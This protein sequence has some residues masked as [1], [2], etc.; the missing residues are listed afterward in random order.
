MV[1]KQA[2]D[3]VV[4]RVG[5]GE[6]H[7]ADRAPRDLVLI[8]GANAAFGGADLGSGDVSGL[9][10]RV[11]L[12]MQ[13]QNQRDV[14]CDLEVGRGHFDSLAAQRL[15]L[16]DEMIGIEDDAVADNR[17]F[18]RPNNAGRKQCKFVSLAVDHES[19]AGVVAALEPHNDVGA[20]RQPIDDLALSFVAP[21]GAD[22]DNIGQR[23]L[24]FR[25]SKTCKAPAQRRKAE[26]GPLRPSPKRSASLSKGAVLAAPPEKRAAH[27]KRAA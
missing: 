10:M 25:L 8:S 15:D 20:D 24:L 13:R 7:Q 19:M 17:Q 1:R 4:Q 2:I 3:L 16:L 22:N 18:S 9:A 6:G 14:L 5:G 27:E 21:L 11:E 12:A 26:P 23:R